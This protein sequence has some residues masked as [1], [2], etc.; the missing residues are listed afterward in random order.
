[1]ADL[2]YSF[3]NFSELRKGELFVTELAGIT[4]S[5]YIYQGGSDG[6]FYATGK[7][8]MQVTSWEQDI[9]IVSIQILTNSHETIE[10]DVFRNLL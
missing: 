5:M 1:M 10:F 6:T 2:I 4:T 8:D 7:Y 9:R 3:K